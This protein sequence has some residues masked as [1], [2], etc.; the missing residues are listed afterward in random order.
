MCQWAAQHRMVQVAWSAYQH[1][2]WHAQVNPEGGLE[3]V[4]LLGQ[5]C[6]S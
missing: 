6:G 3:P 5:H 2:T 1:R 4:G